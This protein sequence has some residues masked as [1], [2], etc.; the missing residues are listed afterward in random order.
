MRRMRAKHV[1]P[2]R[3]C[4]QLLPVRG[5]RNDC[6]SPVSGTAPKTLGPFNGT[7]STSGTFVSEKKVTVSDGELLRALMEDQ[8]GWICDRSYTRRVTAQHGRDSLALAVAAD[9]LAHPHEPEM[10][11]RE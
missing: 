5:T 11:A 7:G 10:P 6:R 3:P 1:W 2:L 9:R 8:I 4:V